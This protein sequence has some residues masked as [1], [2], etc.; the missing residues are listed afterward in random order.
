[1]KSRSDLSIHRD[2]SPEEK[3]SGLTI[4]K[5]K[6][7]HVPFKKMNFQC[8]NDACSLGSNLSERGSIQMSQHIYKLFF[9]GKGYLLTHQKITANYK[10]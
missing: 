8:L 6:I 4:I 7:G 1:M 5:I 9:G 10:E 3:E 2:F